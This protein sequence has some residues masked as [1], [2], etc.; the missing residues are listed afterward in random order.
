MQTD[1]H[2]P[3]MPPAYPALPGTPQ[4]ELSL[5][6]ISTPS[7]DLSGGNFTDATPPLR[8]TVPPLS[9]DDPQGDLHLLGIDPETPYFELNLAGEALPVPRPA[10]LADA[11]APEFPGGANAPT[12]G[13]QDY[14]VPPLRPYDLTE[15]GIDAMSPMQPDPP[16]LQFAQPLG[17][18]VYPASDGQMLSDPMAPGLDDYDRPA[19]LEISDALAG[20]PALPDLHTPMLTQQVMMPDRPGDLASG[21]L[22]AMRDEA[23]YRQL[24]DASYREVYMDAS[25]INTTRRRHMDLLMRGLDEEEG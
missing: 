23:S 13:T 21:A 3:L 8:T 18:S 2:P 12:F 5:A 24:G 1:H 9:T 14:A 15:P 7:T 6:G 25:G 16:V 19:G 17:L 11:A 20:D 10:S 4:P 22:D